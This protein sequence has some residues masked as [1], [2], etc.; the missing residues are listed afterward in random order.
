MMGR[1][2]IVCA[3][4]GDSVLDNEYLEGTVVAELESR[5]VPGSSALAVRLDSQSQQ[6]LEPHTAEPE[7]IMVDLDGTPIERMP[8]MR[9][10]RGGAFVRLYGRTSLGDSRFEKYLGRGEA[11]EQRG[12]IPASTHPAA[13]RH[14]ALQVV[15]LSKQDFGA[16]LS[17]SLQGLTEGAK[18]AAK[19]RWGGASDF[20]RKGRLIFMWGAFFG[21][22]LVAHYRGRWARDPSGYNIV[23]LPR[24]N[25]A[26]LSVAPFGLFE[27]LADEGDS[28]IATEWIAGIR[29]AMESSEPSPRTIE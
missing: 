29:S 2:L 11:V 9:G 6:K 27:R 12:Q 17:I 22:C 24:G 10:Y 14:D 28:G 26:P 8:G 7:E 18:L 3:L 21:E 25:L 20:F 5:N 1:K 23:L 19:V 13:F 15:E 16:N 4:E